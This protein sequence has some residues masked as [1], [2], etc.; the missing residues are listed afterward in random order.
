MAPGKG[1]AEKHGY[2]LSLTNRDPAAAMRFVNLLVPLAKG[3]VP[4]VVKDVVVKPEETTIS[5]G[6]KWPDGKT[7]HVRV[8]L[9]WT[10]EMP[11]KKDPVEIVPR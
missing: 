6:L 3:E 4:P 1:R 11:G 10:S 2:Q 7:E 8:D 9:G 5:F